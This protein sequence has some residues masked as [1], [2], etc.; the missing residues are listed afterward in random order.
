MDRFGRRVGPVYFAHALHADLVG[1]DGKVIACTYCHYEKCGPPRRCGECHL[2][3]R[4][5]A[6]GQPRLHST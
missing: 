4:K 3:R 2:G 1:L 6:P 5:Q